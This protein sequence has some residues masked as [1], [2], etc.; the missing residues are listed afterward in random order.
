[1]NVHKIK[2]LFYAS[3]GAYMNGTTSYKVFS[4]ISSEIFRR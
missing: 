2:S 3:F 4:D 1:M